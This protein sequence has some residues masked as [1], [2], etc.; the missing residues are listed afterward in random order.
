MAEDSALRS[1]SQT[2][3]ELDDNIVLRNDFETDFSGTDRASSSETGQSPPDEETTILRPIFLNISSS[4]VNSNRGAASST[5]RLGVDGSNP[6]EALLS[7]TTIDAS[8]DVYATLEDFEEEADDEP[9]FLT[10]Q[11]WVSVDLPDSIY[12]SALPLTRGGRS[13]PLWHLLQSRGGRSPQESGRRF[14]VPG[15][16]D[17][18]RLSSRTRIEEEAE[19][20]VVD[21]GYQELISDMNTG[22]N[23]SEPEEFDNTFQAVDWRSSCKGIQDRLQNVLNSERFADVYFYI[24]GGNESRTDGGITRSASVLSSKPPVGPT[25]RRSTSSA[26]R[27]QNSEQQRRITSAIARASGN[28]SRRQASPSGYQSPEENSTAAEKAK[29]LTEM[30][31]ALRT[32][33]PGSDCSATSSTT[34]TPL[35]SSPSDFPY[36]AEMTNTAIM[37]QL[38]DIS[39]IDMLPSER[40]PTGDPQLKQNV[41]PPS[42]DSS[43]TATTLHA[44]SDVKRFGVHRL[45]LATASPVFEAMF[46][47]AFAEGTKDVKGQKML[48]S[49]SAE[50]QEIHV[51]DVTAEAFQQCLRYIYYDNMTL[52]DSVEELYDILYAAKKYLLTP[53]ATACTNRLVKLMAPQNVLL[54]LNRCSAMDEED[55]I[56]VCWH[57]IDVLTPDVLISDHFP[58]L[59]RNT[60]LKLISRESLYCEEWEIFEALM[61]WCKLECAR[62]GSNPSPNNVATMMR[63]FLPHIRFTTMSLE[64][65]IFHVSKSNILSLEVQHNILLQIATKMFTKNETSKETTDSSEKEEVEFL[66]SNGSSPKRRGPLLHKCRRFLQSITPPSKEAYWSDAECI[67]FQVS[68][69]VFLA[70]V[71]VFGPMN[72]DTHL[73][74]KIDLKQCTLSQSKTSS[75]SGTTFRSTGVSTLS[76]SGHRHNHGQRHVGIQSQSH[77][78]TNGDGSRRRGHGSS[79][80]TLS[81]GRTRSSNSPSASTPTTSRTLFKSAKTRSGTLSSVEIT[82]NCNSPTNR[83]IEAR[84][85]RPVKLSPDKHYM[86]TVKPEDGR[87]TRC[88]LGATASRSEVLTR[89]L[90]P[91]PDDKA[92]QGESVARASPR[93]GRVKF[94][95]AYNEKHAG[96]LSEAFHVPELLFFPAS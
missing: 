12:S 19:A 38:S 3:G 28:T 41:Q 69:P 36:L 92:P 7:G 8:S 51:T 53:L 75:G 30:L 59:E 72:K 40:G 88:Y 74:V 62:K 70:G 10:T 9:M 64:D 50:V 34:T 22:A 80:R 13:R 20:V 87:S 60:L 16:E 79:G 71:G 67:I 27:K 91:R 73:K 32:T 4:L 55:L 49:T 61:R 57:T 5:I 84:F 56:G 44:E 18:R 63:E 33:D 81:D 48:P 15:I 47:G 58:E 39:D 46:F 93:H 65:F 6:T 23:S 77:L 24:G 11:P 66:E 14:H 95:F 52:T 29:K 25:P 2:D 21:D 31:L 1:R 42:P 45:V 43:V 86:I 89:T 78:R 83:I 35:S 17:T 94:T 37:C 85:P 68:K 82:L 26:V 96:F 54:Q 90:I 76:S